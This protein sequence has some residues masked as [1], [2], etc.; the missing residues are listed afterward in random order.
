MTNRRSR[1]SEHRQ[2]PGLDAIV[3]QVDNQYGERIMRAPGM[4]DPGLTYLPT[5]IAMLD[6]ALLG[7]LPEGRVSMIFG[8]ENCIAADQYLKFIVVD[9]DTGKVQNCK[10]GTI[11]RLYERVHGIQRKG[12]GNYQRSNTKN[13]EFYVMAVNE[14]NRIIRNR[15]ADVVCTGIQSVFRLTTKSGRELRATAEHK[16]FT[17]YEYIPVKDLSVG[18]KVM[19]H[20]NVPAKKEQKKRQVQYKDRNVKWYY[21]GSP[22][23]VSE[24]GKTYTYYRVRESRLVYEAYQNGVTPDQYADM[25]NTET[26]LPDD[27]WTIPEGMHVHHEN[28]NR[29]DDSIENLTLVAAEDHFRHHA[30]VRHNDLR[31]IAVQ[32]EVV[33][34]VPDGETLTYDVK[35]FYP[36]NNYIAGGIVTHNCGKT[37]MTMRIAA[38]ALRKNPNKA[39][40]FIDAEGTYDPA[41]AHTH[42]LDTD[43]LYLVQPESGEQAVN[44]IDAVL[45]EPETGCV[46]IDSLPALVPQSMIDAAAEDAIVARRAQLIGRLCSIILASYNAMR[47]QGHKCTV[48]FVNQWRH[49]IGPAFGDPRVL[50]GGQQPKYLCSHMI[51]VKAKPH[52]GKDG[53]GLDRLLHTDHTFVLKKHKGA[54]LHT[55]EYR[56]IHDPGH[57]LGAGT[58]E[59]GQSVST[60]GKSLGFVA[61]EG[62]VW[63]VQGYEGEWRRKEELWAEV[64]K[65]TGLYL[66]IMRTATVMARRQYGLLDVPPD[67]DLFGRVERHVAQA[68]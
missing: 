2:F 49:K 11:E 20:N 59:Q 6:Y 12:S 37:T 22:H 17:G 34:I 38:S 24:N 58:I 56:M 52:N 35:C 7:G 28:E 27:W 62:N 45:R 63:R 67:G 54:A 42:G 51:E 65:G 55:G 44:I 64:Q 43:R 23:H 30:N 39:C 21:K 46:I 60:L 19:V 9:P 68:A 48:V 4:V 1:S 29:R 3:D 33:S 47:P 57:E 18:S 13:S 32:D 53:N 50:P 10:G 5:G 41:W 61:R 26:C 16:I 31:F 66:H 15:V 14:E 8:W 36:Y 25:L 40:I